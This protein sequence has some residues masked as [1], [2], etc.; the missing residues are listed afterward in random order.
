MPYPWM[1]VTH[2]WLGMGTL[3]SGPIVGYLARS[4]S[5]FYTFFGGLLLLA[6][7]DIYRYRLLLIYIGIT[8]ILFGLLLLGIDLLEGLPLYWSLAEGPTGTIFGVI[9]LA[10]IRRMPVE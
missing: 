1:N 9:I 4:T 2:Q 7:F 5:A 6:S 3:P 8:H 10:L